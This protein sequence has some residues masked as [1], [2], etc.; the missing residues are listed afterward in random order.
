[1]PLALRFS[2]VVAL[3]A[4]S[5]VVAAR[6]VP[7]RFDLSAAPC[8]DAAAFSRA[9]AQ[10]Q[11][12][13]VQVGTGEELVVSIAVAGVAPD[14][15]GRVVFT[16]RAGTVQTRELAAATCDELSGALV[17]VTALAYDSWREENVGAASP[18]APP[19]IPIAGDASFPP[20]SQPLD[21]SANAR[22]DLGIFGSLRAFGTP[23]LAPGIVVR[24][25][26]FRP[27]ARAATW[28]RRELSLSGHV[29]FLRSGDPRASAVLALA[30]LEACPLGLAAGIVDVATCAGVSAGVFSATAE[31]VV[32]PSPRTRPWVEPTLGARLRLDLGSTIALGAFVGAAAPIVRDELVVEPHGTAFA[33]SPVNVVG[34]GGVVA[35][36][37]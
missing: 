13:L 16:E 19:T 20:P 26:L 33:A 35:T 32:R 22:L 1:M 27:Q 23:T 18:A 7:V 9:L 29:A 8:V 3:L 12:A 24:A 10:R 11:P 6:E 21:R 31:D 28:F 17:L 37:W 30:S 2:C 14:L 34:H 15:R 5:R 25:S 4:I 36:I